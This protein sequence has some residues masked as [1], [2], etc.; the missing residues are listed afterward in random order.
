MTNRLALVI[1]NTHRRFP[2][3]ALGGGAFRWIDNIANQAVVT[4]RTPQVP[5]YV[6]QHYALFKD[7]Q[8]SSADGNADVQHD[9][10]FYMLHMA[11]D[12]TVPGR[13]PQQHHRPHQLHCHLPAGPTLSGVA[14]LVTNHHPPPPPI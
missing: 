1:D 11:C 14:P 2:A 3:L 10:A 5:G 6:F 9:S 8:R 4:G 12:A 7:V 13:G